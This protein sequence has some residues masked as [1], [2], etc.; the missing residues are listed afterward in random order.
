MYNTKT[1]GDGE[2]TVLIRRGDTAAEGVLVERYSDKLL[3]MLVHITQ[4][5][6]L[7]DDLHQE[8]FRI[9]IARL[10]RGSLREPE[11]LPRF[12]LRTGRNLAL[13]AHRR[14]ARRGDTPIMRTDLADPAPGQLDRMLGREREAIVQ[15]LLAQVAPDRYRQILQRFYIAG[16]DK[17][18]ICADLGMGDLHFN[19]VLF[20]ARRRL[21]DLALR[22]DLENALG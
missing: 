10:R 18:R 13:G 8:T 4:D 15:R 5:K 3:R 11:K 1:G 2:L 19:R 20:R 21:R 16:E 17:R 22:I 12:I 9:V 14:Q 7:S 6:A